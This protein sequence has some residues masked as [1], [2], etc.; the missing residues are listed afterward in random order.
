METQDD[1]IA[2]VT[3]DGA[4]LGNPS[5]KKK[6]SFF[7]RC[8]QSLGDCIDDIAARCRLLTS[9][10]PFQWLIIGAIFVAGA[11]VG[12]STY[13]PME[14]SVVLAWVDQIVLMLF[15]LECI[16]KIVACGREPWLYWVG[17]E[18]G[19]NNFD[20][21]IVVASLPGV[22]PGDIDVRF[23][24]LLRLMRVTKLLGK[25]R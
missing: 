19:W 9:G 4:L 18:W 24:R 23:L 17:P 5:G 15:I 7:R 2:K 22:V 12:I 13:P 10:G 21:W 8:C 20:F 25:V 14:D 3:T 6:A 16:L 1:T 11:N